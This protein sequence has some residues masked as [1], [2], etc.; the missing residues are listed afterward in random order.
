MKKNI[1]LSIIFFFLG[2]LTH[3][4]FFPDILSNGITDVKNIAIPNL[5]PTGGGQQNDPLITKIGFDGEQFSRHNVTIGF[6]R[7]IQIVNTS[8]NTLMELQSTAKELTTTRGYATSEA[9]QMQFNQKGQFVVA[10]KKN[11]DEKLVITVK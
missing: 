2:F 1:I 11:P 10:D 5:T 6:T 7:Y 9:V 4:F 8:E 3:A